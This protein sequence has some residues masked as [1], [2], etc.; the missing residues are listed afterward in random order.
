MV[1]VGLN[2]NGYIK[3]KNVTGAPAG[4]PVGE[5]ENDPI[6]FTPSELQV[7]TFR[8]LPPFTQGKI[9]RADDFEESTIYPALLSEGLLEEDSDDTATGY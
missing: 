1:E 5:L 2:K 3:I 4:I 7:E 8:R 9:K 6:I